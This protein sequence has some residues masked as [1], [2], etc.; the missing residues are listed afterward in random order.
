M[1]NDN[2]FR[3]KRDERAN[4]F[5]QWVGIGVYGLYIVVGWIFWEPMSHALGSELAIGIL[6][7]ISVFVAVGAIR[8]S[9]RAEWWFSRRNRRRQ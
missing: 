6:G 2:L 1:S 5:G 9:D 3:P 7:A 4:T 8:I